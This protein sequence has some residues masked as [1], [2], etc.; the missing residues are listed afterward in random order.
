MLLSVSLRHLGR[1]P[2]RAKDLLKQTG[3][4]D[5][6]SSG[7]AANA[8]YPAATALRYKESTR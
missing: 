1:D 6:S 7:E 5:I 4:Q 2:L 8:D 3:A